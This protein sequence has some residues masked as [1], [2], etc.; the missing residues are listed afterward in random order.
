MGCSWSRRSSGVREQGREPAEEI[1]VTI[2]VPPAHIAKLLEL[3]PG[4]TTLA[5]RRTRRV[6]G[7]VM[8][9]ADS[10]YPE[11]LVRGTPIAQPGD[12]SPGTYAV[13]EAMGHGW[14]SSR[15]E[16]SIRM[17]TREEAARLGLAE[18]TPVGE[19]IRTSRAADGKPV[20][21]QVSV[22]PGDRNKIVYDLQE[23]Q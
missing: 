12:V 11:A 6:D 14:V 8:L 17:P 19:H 4:E 7:E 13:L 5:R 22:L 20:R 21:I 9:L 3:A 2:T 23:D 10:Y 15:D 18:L 1:E 16:I